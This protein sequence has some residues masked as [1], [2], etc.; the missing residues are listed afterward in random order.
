MPVTGFNHY[1]L[2]APRPLLDT[3]RDFYCDVVGLKQGERP[4]FRGFGYW[5]YAGATDV[6]HLSECSTDENRATH[7]ATT[8]DHA[9]FTCDDAAEMEA[10]LKQM[11]IPF[12]VRIVEQTATRQIFFKDPAGNGV[13]LNCPM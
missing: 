4:A 7:T 2:R 8:F 5:L 9:A 13:E 11:Q 12:Q 10:R 3:L 6:L 1:N